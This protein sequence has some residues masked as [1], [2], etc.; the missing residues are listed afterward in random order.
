MGKDAFE[1]LMGPTEQILARQIGEYERIN[2][3][4][5]SSMEVAGRLA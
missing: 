4:A 2:A 5:S 3:E 1:R